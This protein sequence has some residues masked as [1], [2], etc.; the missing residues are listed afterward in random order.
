EKMSIKAEYLSK[1][2]LQTRVDWINNPKINS[3]MFFE[4]PASLEKTSNW[5]LANLRNKNRVD[6]S[7]FD[8]TGDLVAM[9]GF[10]GIDFVNSH[11]EFYVMVNPDLQGQGFGKRVSKWMFNYAFLK[12]N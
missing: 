2:D 10:T 9:G 6:F 12:F 1:T 5:F 7:F 4:T 8:E 11:A 3:S